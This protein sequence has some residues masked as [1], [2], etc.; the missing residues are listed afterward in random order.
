MVMK[1]PAIEERL[2]AFRILLLVV[3]A[4]CGLRTAQ[5]TASAIRDSNPTA[6]QSSQLQIPRIDHAPVLEEF[7][8][9]QP[10]EQWRG[11]LA[12]V[13]GFIQRA[14]EDGKPPTQETD[15]Y[16][17]YDARALY[18]I[19]VARDR[20]PQRIR[21]RMDHRETIAADEDQVGIYI[22]TFHDRRRAY[23]FECN[24]LGV[25]D[26]SMFSEDTLAADEGFDTVWTSHGQITSSGYVVLMSI[27][28]KSLR[29]SHDREQTW[30]VA[31]W[32]FLGRRSEGSWWPRV[33]SEY[34][35]FLSQAVPAH[36]IENISP[37][38]NFQLNPY[39]SWRAF[40]SV[41]ARDPSN[42]VYT[43]RS[44]QV[45]TGLDAKAILKDS[46]VL[47]LTVKP[48]FSQVESDQ[49]QITTNQRYEL[50]YPEKRPFFTENASYFDVPM[51]VPGQ[52]FLST[53]RIAEPD[54]GARLTG[55]LGKYSIG[56]LLA[57]DAAPGKAVLASDPSA[58]KHAIF[59]VMRI[60][61]EISSAF[62]VGATYA[63]RTFAGSF[64]RVADVDTTFGIGR[65]W[66][67][68]VMG[69]YN[70]NRELN[71]STSS[72]GTLDATLNRTSRGFNY[73]GYFLNR[74]PDFQPAMSYI[75]H[76]DW[77]EVG[78]TFAYQFWPS[79][80]WITR[81][82]TEVY[83]A[84][85]WH[86][87]GVKNWEGVAQTVK[88]DIKH[89]TNLTAY[90]TLWRDVLGPEDFSQLKEVLHFPSKPAYG[91]SLQSTQARFMSFKVFTEWGTRSNVSPPI[92][93]APV[94]AHYRQAEADLTLLTSRGLSVANSYLFD[95]N[96][97][98]PD[99]R[100]MYNS[101][102]IRSQWNWQFNRELSLRFIGQYTAVLANTFYTAT[103]TARG[104][105][106][107]FLI[108]Y[109]VHPGTAIYAG[110]NSNLSKPGPIVA[111][112]DPNRF[113]NDGRQFFV[114][115]SY[116]LRF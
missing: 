40:H 5:A 19:F 17:G 80:S 72:G 81:L 66:K 10:P 89:N 41:D 113:A 111:P 28:F 56:A 98:L 44:A 95:R 13:D 115:A 7:L 61:R 9:M 110:F 74:S 69:A 16:L 109:L 62:N 32:R 25:Q 46:L 71:G 51:V 64:S 30:N 91:I 12:K 76:S 70:W 101:H 24:P 54:F 102:T 85:S 84:R 114:K 38:R 107:D 53:R 100:A 26:D 43:G 49:P 99:G 35:G 29:F 65:T 73:T 75:N 90:V 116:L 55:K 106:G 8:T 33:S 108:S 21:A 63:D 103:P 15:A 50:F 14:P 86:Y 57:D 87:D 48:D 67:G 60:N 88:M 83:A 105:N 37:G 42:P 104:F 34:R 20:E 82:W 4:V 1:T 3:V 58:G 2:V 22:D 96:A 11:K 27:P 6:P 36:G 52:H 79:N 92:G 39:V 112:F 47:D 77:R 45:L 97:S 59:D 18:V 23:Q 31:L 94:Q 78:Q 68:T 93:Q